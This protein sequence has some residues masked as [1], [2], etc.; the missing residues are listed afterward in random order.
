MNF[1]NHFIVYELFIFFYLERFKRRLILYL[2][3]IDLNLI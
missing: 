3:I 2:D 1:T